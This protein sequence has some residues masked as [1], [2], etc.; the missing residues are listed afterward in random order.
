LSHHTGRSEEQIAKDTD[1]DNFLSAEKA[2]EYGIVDKIYSHRQDGH[3]E[4]DKD[5]KKS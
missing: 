4:K 1:R 3:A 2:L 5:K